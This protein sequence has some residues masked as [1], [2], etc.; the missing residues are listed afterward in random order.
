MHKSKKR[1]KQIKAWMFAALFLVIA[2]AVL[3]RGFV[4]YKVYPL[5]YRQIIEQRS[6]E[7]SLDP[8]LVSAVICAESRF[9]PDAVSPK[10]AVGLMQIM[11]DTGEWISGKMG[12][13]NYSNDMLRD[14][15]VNIHFGCWYLR[16]LYE[17]FNGDMDKV[18]AAYNAG[19]RNVEKWA[20]D[21][22]LETIP[23]P[24]T[25]NYLKIVTRNYY[26]YKEIYND[27]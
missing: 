23:F 17:R 12:L 22:A 4:V 16:Y 8:Y 5:D 26:I 3:L 24:E 10:G 25:E 6:K 13:E 20:R 15:D 18:L 2:I 27:F 7:Y 9:L 19:P 1:S 14:P 21:G 11:P